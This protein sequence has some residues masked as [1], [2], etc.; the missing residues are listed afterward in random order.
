MSSSA[1]SVQSMPT[2]RPSGAGSFVAGTAPPQQVPVPGA[3]ASS[4]SAEL[5]AHEAEEEEDLVQEQA[6]PPAQQQEREALEEQPPAQ[7]E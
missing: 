2:S 6:Q 5:G 4:E 3:T 7:Q 1:Q